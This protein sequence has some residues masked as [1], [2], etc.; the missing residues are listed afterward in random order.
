MSS[1]KNL[2]LV[3]TGDD[4]TEEF[5]IAPLLVSLL[6][7]LKQMGGLSWHTLKSRQPSLPQVK[8]RRSMADMDSIVNFLST[9]WRDAVAKE[10][11]N[12]LLCIL[13]DK[14][15]ILKAKAPGWSHII[16][17]SRYNAVLARQQLL[18][19]TA[20]RMQVATLID[21]TNTLMSAIV[22][23]LKPLLP[24]IVTE[25]QYVEAEGI[26]EV[27]ETAM[28]VVS[29]VNVVE[30][31]SKKAEGPGMAQEILDD[32]GS[33]SLP[34]TLKSKLKAVAAKAQ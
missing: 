17:N 23:K 15:K 24:D 21:H 27:A 20:V 8:F 12:G 14:A 4:K 34:D 16:S 11:A 2:V 7:W 25:P 28:L 18:D 1:R 3:K 30:N 13:E 10:L 32:S 6:E 5:I 29:G 19:G 9:T 33:K 31:Y 22:M 26:V